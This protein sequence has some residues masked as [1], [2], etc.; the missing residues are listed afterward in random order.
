MYIYIYIRKKKQKLL[1]SEKDN[2]D[3]ERSQE[4][5]LLKQGLVCVREQGLV[6][7]YKNWCMNKDLVVGSKT[8]NT[9]KEKKNVI[10][11]IEFI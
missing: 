2:F 1:Y 10:D 11:K 9:R 3:K 4:K 6:C 7:V 8:W 5:G